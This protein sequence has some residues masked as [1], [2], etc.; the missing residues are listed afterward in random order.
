MKT[1]WMRFC[2]LRFCGITSRPFGWAAAPGLAAAVLA[3]VQAVTVARVLAPALAQATPGTAGI[4]RSEKAPRPRPDRLLQGVTL[5]DGFRLETVATEPQVRNPVAFDIA[6]DGRIFVAETYRAWESVFDIRDRHKQARKLLRGRGQTPTKPS[7]DRIAQDMLEAEIAAR[8]V[9]DRQ[10]FV[11][12]YY[13]NAGALMTASTEG[14]A[15][16]VPTPKGYVRHD[17]AT[18]M[19]DP[20]GGVIAGI[21]VLNDA[22]YVANIPDV[23]KYT[24]PQTSSAQAHDQR[25]DHGPSHNPSN[26]KGTIADGVWGALRPFGARPARAGDRA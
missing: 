24:A 12:T 6:D 3:I 19:N 14:V 7:V 25:P 5:P 4:T 11:R 9:A 23:I 8:T 15:A 22:V 18:D 21:G 17:F 20:M 26:E 16:L 10:D 2:W 1:G 13:P